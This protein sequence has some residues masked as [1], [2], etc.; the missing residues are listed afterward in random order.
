M[1]KIAVLSGKGGTGKTFVSTNL[2]NI[3]SLNGNKTLLC[4]V[5]AEEPDSGLF[6][7]LEN[8]T[9]KNV[10]KK[11]PEVN[12]DKCN[13]CGL[14]VENCRFSAIHVSKSKSM[15][16]DTLCHGCGL[17]E[18]ICPEK[19]ITEKDKIIGIINS[20]RIRD[21][22]DFTEGVLNIGEPSAVP[23]I[24]EL[25]KSI[26]REYDFIF[27][28]SPPGCSCSVVET[29][30]ECDYALIVTEPTPFGIHDL[31]MAIQVAK[32]MSIPYSIILNRWD[33]NSDNYEKEIAGD[34]NRVILKIPF[35]KKIAE[36]YSSGLLVSEQEEKYATLFENLYSELKKEVMP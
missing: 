20:Y 13:L 8:K 5:D 35:E 15:I 33:E 30:R 26:D 17:C 21:D 31:N 32:D 10:L 4:D 18:K 3:S 29:L 27:F 28:D 1:V 23:V 36:Y 16:F 2:A 6:F 22:F 11:I 14:C 25:K 24:R 12:L 34:F 9:E 7:S 19:A